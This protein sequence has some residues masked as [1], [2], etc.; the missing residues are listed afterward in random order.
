M[1]VGVSSAETKTEADRNDIT[2]IRYP[3]DY[4]PDIGMFGFL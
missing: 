4:K 1:H 2:E 3:H